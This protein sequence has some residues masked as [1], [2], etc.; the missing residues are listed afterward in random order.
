[1]EGFSLHTKCDIISSMKIIDQYK[2]E[3]AYIESLGNIE[4]QKDY[5]T[6][7]LG[8]PICLKRTKYLLKL[9]GNPER[10]IKKYIHIGGT[11]GK[12][13][14]ANFVHEILVASGK[15]S[16]LFTSPFVTETI[17]KYKIDHKLISPSTF[18]KI[19]NDLKSTIDICAQKSPYGVPSYFEVCFVIAVIYFTQNRCDYFVSEVG[20][21]GEF[22]ATNAPNKKKIAIITHVDYDH[23]ELLGNT[24]EKIASTKSKIIS[25][26]S[27]FFTNEPR[28]SLRKIFKSQCDHENASFNLIRTKAQK[29][30]H[31]GKYLSFIYKNTKFR[32]NLFGEHQVNNAILA[33]EVSKFM[34]INDIDIKKGLS[35]TRIPGRFEIVKYKPYIVLDVA[36][37]PDKI[38]TTLENLGLLGYK[39]LFVIYASA[40][41]KDLDKIAN[42]FSGFTDELIVT[43]Y[44]LT[45]R[46]CADPKYVEKIWQKTNNKLKTKIMLD[47]W[48]ALEYTQKK[49][50]K[51]DIILILGSFFSVGE[52]RKKWVS[53]EKILRTRKVI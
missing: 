47:P 10:K 32:L 4:G 21:G 37:N 19:V 39:K 29:I 45:L 20:L 24:L 3:I 12:G 2:K 15:K 16:G 13:S 43:K 30:T 49:A 7:R 36:H 44:F 40:A 31:E 23:T 41:N 50:S 42:I 34:K 6:D 33:I 9:L 25:R 53:S 8:A 11:S 18:A 22:D 14:V 51:S 27:S 17:E 1:M 26:N 35:V 46:K 48:Q 38:K 52:L 5:Q 28:S